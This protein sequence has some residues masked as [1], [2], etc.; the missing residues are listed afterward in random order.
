MSTDTPEVVI[1]EPVVVHQGRY[2]LYRKP[3]GGMHLVYQRDDKEEPDH[4]EL[5]G[6]LLHLAEMA[7]E[8]KLSMG[9]MLREV[10]K[11]RGTM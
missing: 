2:R 4:F 5:P 3:D 1:T 10:V 11:L 6:A 7:G 9:E 8:G